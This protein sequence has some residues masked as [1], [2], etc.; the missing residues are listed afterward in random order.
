MK[1]QTALQ[2]ARNQTDVTYGEWCDLYVDM[3]NPTTAQVKHALTTAHPI[4]VRNGVIEESVVL[5]HRR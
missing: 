1:W 3:R 2:F 4:L 5:S